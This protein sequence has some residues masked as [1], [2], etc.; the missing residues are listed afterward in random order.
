MT[1]QRLDDKIRHD[2]PIVRVH[3]WAIGVEDPRDLDPQLMLSP[4]IEEQ[5]LRTEHAIIITGARSDRIDITPI[6]F[7]LWMNIWIAIDLGGG[8]LEDLRFNSLGQAEH[9]YCAVHA[10]L[11][12][13]HRVM[14][15][16]D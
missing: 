10:C 12:R 5:G 4:I 13:L 7:W 6:I 1:E 9:I 8:G 11:R 16:M 2:A 15:V 3:A 14:L